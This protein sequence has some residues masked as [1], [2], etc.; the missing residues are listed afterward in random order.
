MTRTN[1]ASATDRRPPFHFH[2]LPRR[3][4]PGRGHDA[5]PYGASSS[6]SRSAGVIAASVSADVVF[7]NR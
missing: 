4:C 1:V 3:A 6:A 5:I 7:P 2:H